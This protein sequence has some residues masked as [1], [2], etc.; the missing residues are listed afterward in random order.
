MVFLFTKWL[1]F[2]QPDALI[3]S[4]C[5]GSC[6]QISFSAKERE[7]RL[8]GGFTLKEGSAQQPRG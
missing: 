1:L 4:H 5:S 6:S 7:A 2:W 3:Q 8:S